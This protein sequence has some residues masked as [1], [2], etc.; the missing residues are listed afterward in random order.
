MFEE[1]NKLLKEAYLNMKTYEE[2]EI[3][4]HRLK[5]ERNLLEQK[6]NELDKKLKKE[7]IEVNKL[8]E[9]SIKGLFYKALGQHEQQLEKVEE[10]IVLARYR[11][12]QAK[13]EL[14]TC[15]AKIQALMNENSYLRKAKSTYKVLYQQKYEGIRNLNTSETHFL[16]AL[17]EEIVVGLK[18]IQELEDAIKVGNRLMTCLTKISSD[19][20]SAQ[21]Y[22]V[23]DMLGGEIIATAGKHSHLE[24]AQSD[25]E[26]VQTLMKQFKQELKEVEVPLD[27]QVNVDGFTKFSDFFFDGFL[28]DWFV[29]SKINDSIEC[30][31]EVRHQVLKALNQLVKMKDEIGDGVNQK[32]VE[33]EQIITY[34]E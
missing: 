34:F 23:W 28:V 30:I 24:S 16:L 6:V 14:E 33:L 31:D 10:A 8:N 13:S 27:F 21:S 4:L 29:Q 9:F 11:Y 22:G 20:D 3:K 32:H 19:L 1:L 15:E 17:E 7:K 18:I 12:Y 25:L 5:E 2:N 26:D